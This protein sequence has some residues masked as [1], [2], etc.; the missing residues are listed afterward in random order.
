MGRLAWAIR[1]PDRGTGFVGTCVLESLFCAN[2]E[3]D[4]GL[5]VDPG[6]KHTELAAGWQERECVRTTTEGKKDATESR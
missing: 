6:A 1:F 5:A 3:L 4:L 2:D